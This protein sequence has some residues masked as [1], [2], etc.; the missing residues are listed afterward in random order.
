MHRQSLE[1]MTLYQANQPFAKL[2]KI[3]DKQKAH[4]LRASPP[5]AEGV[6]LVERGLVLNRKKVENLENPIKRMYPDRNIATGMIYLTVEAIL[7]KT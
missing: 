4:P 6:N 3:L 1:G 2:Q 7:G 5:K